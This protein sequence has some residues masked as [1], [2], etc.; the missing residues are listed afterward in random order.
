MRCRTTWLILASVAGGLLLEGPAL[1]DR[2]EWRFSGVA[3]LGS[4]TVGY[5]RT[6]AS[7]FTGGGRGRVGYGLSDLFEVGGN[8]ALANGSGLGFSGAQ[9]SDGKQLQP[10][11]LYANLYSIE[12]APDIRFVPDAR[13]IGF[14]EHTRPYVGVRA[15]MLIRIL[16]DIELLNPGDGKGVFPSRWNDASV[17][18]FLAPSFGVEHRFNRNWT[19]GGAFEFLYAGSDYQFLG[20]NLELGWSRY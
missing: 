17:L 15:G 9:M 13:F 18:P 5:A 10:G 20:A 7:P 3:T 14:F 19:V 2:Q 6:T 4:A 8:L 16:S 11:D 1:A 12:I